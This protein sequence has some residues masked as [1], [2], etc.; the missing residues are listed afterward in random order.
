[1][2]VINPLLVT[3]FANIFSHS[4]GCLFIFSVVSFVVQKLSNI[5]RSHLLIFAFISF[6]LGDGSKK[7]LLWFMQ[8]SVLPVFSSRSFIGSGLTVRSLI[9]FEFIFCGVC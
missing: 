9:H 3:L 6:T 8:K 7:I 2:L 4:V 5:I 1:M